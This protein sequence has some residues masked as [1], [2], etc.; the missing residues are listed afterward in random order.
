MVEGHAPQFLPF[1]GGGPPKVVEGQVRR[2]S[3]S[4]GKLRLRRVGSHEDTKTRKNLGVCGRV[5]ASGTTLLGGESAPSAIPPRTGEGDRPKGGG[6][7]RAPQPNPSGLPAAPPKQRTH[8]AT[9]KPEGVH[10]EIAEE[11]G[12]A[13]EGSGGWGGY[14]TFHHNPDQ[15]VSCL[16]AA[17]TSSEQPKTAIMAVYRISVP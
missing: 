4:L 11:K 10:A 12:D 16:Q 13:E 15:V 8:A 2:S 1:R 3:V 6:G 9:A 7:A 17:S 14:C 5:S